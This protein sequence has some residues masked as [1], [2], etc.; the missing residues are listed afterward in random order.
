MTLDEVR[1]NIDRVDKEIKA[2]FKERMELA[3]NVAKVKAETNDEIFK[4]DREIAII[5]NLTGDV[6]DNIKKEYIALIK[7]IMEISRKYQY[8]RT[9]ELRGGLDVR[10]VSNVPEI[11]KAAMIKPELYIC[12]MMSKDDVVTVDTFDEVADLIENGEVDAGIGILEDVSVKASDELHFILVNRD[13]YINH[14]DLIESGGVKRKVVMFSKDL[15]VDE[16]HNRM[17]IMFVCHNKS[18]ALASILSMISDYGVNLTEIH[19]S[20]N[21]KAEWN[22]EF[23]VEIEANF[24]KQETKALIFQLMNETEQFKILGSYTCTGD[25]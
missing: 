18:G 2:L 25:V 8:G 10:Y 22:Y 7:R 17:K 13:L 6:D 3:D 24:L 9:L 16:K 23:F 12:N 20:P 1:S 19:S 5:D 4:P 15:Y 21:Q 14:C 11:K